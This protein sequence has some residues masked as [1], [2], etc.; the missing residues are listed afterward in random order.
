[1]V[2]FENIC[3][4]QRVEVRWNA[5]IYRG[6]VKYKGTIATKKGDWVGVALDASAGDSN[7][8]LHG[9]RYFQCSQDHGIF[10]R[11]DRI[12]FIPSIRCLYNKYHKV[13][14]NSY[15]DEF[16]FDK[17]T[18]PVKDGPH[19][20]IHLSVKD[21]QRAK[22]SLGD[23]Y[24]SSG[25][26][27]EKPKVYSL[28]HSISSLIPAATM[29]RSGSSSSTFRYSSRPIHVDYWEDEEFERKP[30]IPKIHMPHTALRNQVRKG[31]EGAHY[32]REM[33]VPTGKDKMKYSQWND[34]S[35]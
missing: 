7:G 2:L 18:P 1:M 21:F 9:R 14:N 5:G 32:V 17:P 4:G 16:L 19:D 33:T 28:R 15:I 26:I 13:A 11:S 27:W 12:R 31:W 25:C 34:I 24:S 35:P 22:T 10:V 20:P 3:V 8:M 29:L 6:V 30:A 23:Y